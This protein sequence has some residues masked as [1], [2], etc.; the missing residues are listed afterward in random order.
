MTTP[1]LPR[2]DEAIVP[3]AGQQNE[4]NLVLPRVLEVVVTQEIPMT[5]FCG[6]THTY[7]RM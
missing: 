1:F 3:N 2:G 6:G 4:H 5:A 7:L